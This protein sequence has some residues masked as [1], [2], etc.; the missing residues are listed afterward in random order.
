[1]SIKLWYHITWLIRDDDTGVRSWHEATMSSPEQ[2]GEC[3]RELALRDGVVSLHL[4]TG[5]P[6]N[7]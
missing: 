6:G 2:A 3:L 4:E 5:V 7:S 1:M